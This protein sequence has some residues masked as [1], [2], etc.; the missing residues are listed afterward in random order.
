MNAFP[1]LSKGDSAGIDHVGISSDF[2]GGGGISGWMDASETPNVTAALISRGYSV[3]DIKKL[4]GENLL[5][6]L[7][8]VEAKAG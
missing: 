4:W 7:A 1:E 6:V 2:D 5:R 3:G 8:E